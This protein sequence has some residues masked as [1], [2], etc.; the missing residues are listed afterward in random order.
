[1]ALL[2]M[3]RHEDNANAQEG[4]LDGCAAMAL[5]KAA[6]HANVLAAS[7]RREDDVYAKAFASATDKRNCQETTL[8]ATQ[9]QYVA[10]LGFMSS[11][12]FF[13]WVA[14]CDASWDGAVAEAPNRTPALAE[15]SLAEERRRHETATQERVLA[16]EANKQRRAATR[17]KAL[18]NE[19][20]TSSGRAGE[21]AGGRGQ[22]AMPGHRAGKSVGR[23]GQRATSSGR[24]EES[25]GG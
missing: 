22:R 2:A 18:A 10:Q 19:A 14:E 1:M 8:H 3:K 16:D 6:M 15:K 13:A 7:R 4:Y 12:E 24:A 23:R 11:S 21:S 20:A 17:D 5:Q 25:A 9:L